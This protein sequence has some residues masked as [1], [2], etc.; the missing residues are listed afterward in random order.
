MSYLGESAVVPQIA[1]VGKAIADKPKLAF[2]D[3][4]LDWVEKLFF[5]DLQTEDTISH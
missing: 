2:L 5:G 1:V 4:L 3:V